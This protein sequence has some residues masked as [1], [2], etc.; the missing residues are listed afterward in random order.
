MKKRFV[1]ESRLGVEYISDVLATCEHAGINAIADDN[2]AK[3][4]FYNP[5]DGKYTDSNILRD[6]DWDIDSVIKDKDAYEE[7]MQDAS[8]E[9]FKQ[10]AVEWNGLEK[11]DDKDDVF[12]TSNCAPIH[13]NFV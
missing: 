10:F 8:G 12:K 1:I 3:I 6:A 7:V 13:G 11:K 4:L 2:S 9:G 5:K